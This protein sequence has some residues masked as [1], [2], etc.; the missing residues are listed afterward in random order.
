MMLCIGLFAFMQWGGALT[1]T[2]K[3]RDMPGDLNAEKIKLLAMPVSKDVSARQTASPAELLAAS[4]PSASPVTVTVPASTPTPLP[5]SGV[6]SQVLPAVAVS[7]TTSPSKPIQPAVPPSV[8]SPKAGSKSCME[9]GEFSGSD[10]VR[11]GQALAEMKLGDHLSSR[12]VEYA[13]GYWVY[14]PPLAN[15]AAVNKKIEEIKALGVDDY[16]V[17]RESRKWN[18]AISL[19][20]FKTEEAAKRYWA[21]MKKKGIRSAQLGERKHK[22]KFTVYVLSQ[23]DA[24]LSARMAALQKEFVNSE[25]KP[26]PCNK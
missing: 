23:V 2:D 11:A 6:A 17:M 16:F 21:L 12:N 25:L 8:A 14:I 24:A 9:W 26:V 1:G 10:L 3:Y 13:S 19:G 5:P 18:N 22:L 4:A 20:V 15:K 7:A